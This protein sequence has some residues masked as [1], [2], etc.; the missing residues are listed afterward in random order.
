MV[1]ALDARFP[2][3]GARNP[4]ALSAATAKV[5]SEVTTVGRSVTVKIVPTPFEGVI[6]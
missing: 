2:I 4:S 1:K 5:T 3:F 6:A